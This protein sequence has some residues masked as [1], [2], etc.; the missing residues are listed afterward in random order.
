MAWVVSGLLNKQIAGELGIS[1]ETVKGASRPRDAQDGG[2]LPGRA[3]PNVRAAWHPPPQKPI[4]VFRPPASYHQGVMAFSPRTRFNEWRMATPLI[5]VVD[6]DQSVRESL[7]RLIRSV[8]F[9]VQVFGSAEE[10]LMEAEGRA[11]GL[12]DPRHPHARD[13]WARASA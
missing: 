1:E 11:V 5:S 8:G 10:F 7:A 6:D 4:A 2:R 9:G 13:E 12:P 3:G